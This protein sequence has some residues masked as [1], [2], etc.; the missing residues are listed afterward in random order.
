MLDILW[1][2]IRNHGT[3]VKFYVNTSL[4]KILFDEINDTHQM[5]LKISTLCVYGLSLYI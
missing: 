5:I 4:R 1:S 2:L 3:N